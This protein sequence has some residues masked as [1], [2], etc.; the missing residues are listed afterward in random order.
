L[1][2]GLTVFNAAA[3]MATAAESTAAAPSVRSMISSAADLAETAARF[4]TAEAENLRI[5]LAALDAAKA[6]AFADNDSRGA[7][8]IYLSGLPEEWG[9]AEV[10]AWMRRR[11]VG[12]YFWLLASG[13]EAAVKF[14]CRWDADAA[15]AALDGC[16]VRG[17]RG[18]VAAAWRVSGQ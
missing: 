17:S 16:F 1:S 12:G 11:Q 14:R 9:R 5:A 10:S 7:H 6:H 2:P 15:I 4:L 18:A 8:T 13:C 3:A